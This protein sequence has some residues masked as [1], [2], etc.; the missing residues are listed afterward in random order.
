MTI[1]NQLIL[2]CASLLLFVPSLAAATDNQSDSFYSAIR[3]N[4]LP[5]PGAMLEQGAGVNVADERGLTP[6]MYAAYAGSA[7]AMRLLIDKGAHVNAQNAFGSTALMW[8][9]TDLKKVRLLTEHGADV[10]SEEHTSELQSRFG[11][12]YAVFCL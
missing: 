6:L 12:S 8:S 10:R 3:A 2:C 11:I 5:R 9:V 1:K 7:D 4:D